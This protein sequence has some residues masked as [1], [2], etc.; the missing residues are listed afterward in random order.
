MNNNFTNTIE[1]IRARMDIVEIISEHVA[2]KKSGKNWLGLCPFHPEK[3]PSFM[4]NPEKNIFKCFGCGAGGDGF[5]FLQR[6]TSQPF[7]QVLSDLANKYGIKITYSNENTD[8]KNQI[9]EINKLTAKYFTENLFKSGKEAKSYLNNR[10]ISD[11]IIFQF[12][13]GYASE[14]WDNLL[15]YLTKEN[16][17]STDLIE[18]SGLIIKRNESDGYYDRFRDRV[19]IP[20]HNDRG[21]IIAFGGRSLNDSNQPK[22]LNSPE[23][24]VFH[25]GKNLY[26]LYQAKESIRSQDSVILMEGYFDAISAHCNGITNVVATLGTALTSDQLRILCKYTDSKRIFIAFDSDLAG[27]SATNR[28]IEVIKN[29]LGGLGGAKILDNNL[30]K[31]SFYEIRVISIPENKD[32]DEYIRNK[33]PEKFRLLVKNAPLLLDYQIESIIKANDINDT[34]G[35]LKVVSQLSEVLA[36]I[37]SSI[38]RSEYIK[39]VSDKLSIREDDLQKELLR[40]KARPYTTKQSLDNTTSSLTKRKEPKDYIITAEKNLLSL[41]FL[42]ES[43]WTVISNQLSSITLSNETL[44]TIKDSIEELVKSYS[45]IDEL[46]TALLNKLADQAEA[47]GL[48][49][50]MIFS[51]EDKYCLKEEHSISLFIKQNLN[52]IER[53]KNQNVEKTLKDKYYSVKND[54]VQSLELQYE[55]RQI[56][57]SRST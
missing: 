52:C 24:P 17:Y 3:T 8:L 34:N 33:G 2:L 1:E 35:K 57:S 7:S 12:G 55:V 38:V 50:D 42:N 23:T 39:I 45:N 32:P 40:L 4:V 21:Q 25:K 5:S 47:I 18:K 26:A 27:G 19:I 20:I 13:L 56:V 31:D 53:F 10:G 54:D 46:T 44:Q 14:S 28:G 49:S 43:Y 22:Y 11:D 16:N 48:V 29:T 9:I 37:S 6:V 36:D 15:R 41:Y 51:L 30:F